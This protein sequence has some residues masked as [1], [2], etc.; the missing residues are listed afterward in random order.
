MIN[1][2]RNNK[3]PNFFIV[4]A[5]KSGTTTLYHYL[6]Q[7]PDIYMSPVKETNYFSTDIYPDEFKDEYKKTMRSSV[8]LDGLMSQ[9][10]GNFVHIAYI[11]E[12]ENYLKLFTGIEQEKASGE[13]S[14]SYLYSKEAAKN[15]KS[16]FPHAKI[17][18]ILRNPLQRAFS[19][20]LMDYA[21][22]LTKSSFLDVLTKKARVNKPG[23][24]ISGLYIELSLY[25]SQAKRYFDNFQ[26][27]NIKVYILEEFTDDFSL[28]LKDIFYFL[29]VDDGFRPEKIMKCNTKIAPKFKRLNFILARTGIKRHISTFTPQTVKEFF[30]SLYYSQINIPVLTSEE[31]GILRDLFRDDIMKLSELLK[32]DLSY[33]NLD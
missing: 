3:L 16:T 8:N 26:K 4:G 5:A 11:R 33:W 32:K 22:G 10:N 31:K 12:W 6:S 20:Y 28:L 27:E 19:H 24:G 9:H 30:K 17:I 14:T 25:Y 23:W 18:M 1:D 2:I 13:A 29:N 15:I 21:L 7:H